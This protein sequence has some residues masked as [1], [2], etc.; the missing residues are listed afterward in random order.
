MRIYLEGFKTSK[1]FIFEASNQSEHKSSLL[2]CRD[3]F[4]RILLLEASSKNP[5]T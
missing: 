1:D 5:Y 4:P 2:L 3:D